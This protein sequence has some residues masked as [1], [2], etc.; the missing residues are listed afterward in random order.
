MRAT[1]VRFILAAAL[2]ATVPSVY[3]ERR[4]DIEIAS[5]RGYAWWAVR[6]EYIVQV[7]GTYEG[8]RPASG[9]AL[10]LRCEGAAD[11]SGIGLLHEGRGIYFVFFRGNDKASEKCELMAT[12]IYADAAQSFE[13]TNVGPPR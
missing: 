4:G 2:A 6:P 13:V 11:K 5:H 9:V 7:F 12:P 8:L 10:T 3:G 1:S